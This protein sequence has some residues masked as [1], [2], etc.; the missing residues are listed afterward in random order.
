M[1]LDCRDKIVVNKWKLSRMKLTHMRVCY[2][3]EWYSKAG[4]GSRCI[5]IR[6]CEAKLQDVEC[7]YNFQGTSES[8]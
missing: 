8:S 5:P 6:S 1:F 3:T 2:M 4:A 7:C